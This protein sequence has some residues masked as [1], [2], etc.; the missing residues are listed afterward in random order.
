MFFTQKLQ[1]CD[2][3]V[4]KTLNQEMQRQKTNLQLIASENFASQAVIDA[5][6]S[7]FTNKYAEGYPNKRYYNGCQSVDI[8]ENLAIKRV[9]EIFGCKYANVQ[10][11]SG[12]QANQAVFLSLLKPG[13]T[14]L[15]FSLSAGG[16]L[17]HG[18]SVNMSGKW[19]NAMHYGVC[20][21]TMKIDCL[22]Y[23]SPSPRDA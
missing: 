15:G 2:P 7:V 5:Q 9:C 22:L 12:S 3:E 18:S 10:P 8:V 21:K 6:G 20:K 13:D 1:N 23:T 19:F 11:H 14:I 17:T 16:H 4:A